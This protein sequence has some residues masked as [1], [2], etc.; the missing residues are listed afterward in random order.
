MS[1]R[2]SGCVSKREGVYMKYRAEGKE[3]LLLTLFAGI[4]SDSQNQ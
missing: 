4:Y 3:N 2:V 1:E